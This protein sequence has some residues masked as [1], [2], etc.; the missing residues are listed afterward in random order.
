MDI[1]GWDERYR[2]TA[3]DMEPTRLLVETASSLPP[4]KALD[5]ACGAGRNSLWLAKHGWSVTAVDGSRMAIEIL[6]RTAPPTIETC[7]A[8]LEI[9]GYVIEPSAWDLIL[10]CRYLQRDLF[11]PAKHGVKPGGILLAIVNLAGPGARPTPTRA[12]A[13]ELASF[14]QDW[15]ILHY[16]EEAVAEIVARKC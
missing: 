7:V 10:I 15:E 9:G 11:E 13:G 8:N 12:A 2:T 3:V 5:L 16:R 14:F 4:G 6:C 1:E